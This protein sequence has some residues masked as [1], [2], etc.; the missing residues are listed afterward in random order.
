MKHR[1][2]SEQLKLVVLKTD[3]DIKSG[4]KVLEACKKHK[5]EPSLYY[6]KMRQYASGT[7]KFNKPM[8]NNVEAKIASEQHTI[9][10]NVQAQLLKLER[11]N[12]KL[13]KIILDNLL[14]S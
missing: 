9:I 12:M 7:Q 5:L 2:T 11:E 14:A 3:A 4:M 8:V 6:V 10:N 13:K 1:R